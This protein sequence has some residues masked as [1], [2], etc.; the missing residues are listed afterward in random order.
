MLLVVGATRELLG[1]GRLLGVEVLPL[2][3]NGGW[4][5]PIGLMLTPPSAFFLIGGLVWA[6]RTLALRG[7]RREAAVAAPTPTT[8]VEDRA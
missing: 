2:V 5:E 4:F 1:T 8:L 3:E 6:S 7:A